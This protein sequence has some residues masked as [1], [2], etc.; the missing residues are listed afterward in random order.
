VSFGIT[1]GKARVWT[2]TYTRILAENE[3]EAVR[4]VTQ[5]ALKEVPSATVKILRT[6]MTP[7]GRFSVTVKRERVA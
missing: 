1:Y 7:S 2:F 4:L 6:R 5:A 3:T